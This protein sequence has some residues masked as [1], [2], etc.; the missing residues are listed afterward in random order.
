M[1]FTNF[2]FISDPGFTKSAWSPQ[3][4]QSSQ[5]KKKSCSLFTYTIYL[6]V[7][8]SIL[9]VYLNDSLV[10]SIPRFNCC[11]C[12]SSQKGNHSVVIIFFIKKKIFLFLWF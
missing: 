3:P 8:H 2:F 5:G 1:I 7:N 12:F 6:C 10:I 4:S 11:F 9:F